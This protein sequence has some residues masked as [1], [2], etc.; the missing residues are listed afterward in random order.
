[1]RSVL[2]AKFYNQLWLKSSD[3]V[4]G[5]LNDDGINVL[6]WVEHEREIMLETVLTDRAKRKRASVIPSPRYSTI[7][8]SRASSRG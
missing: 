6:A 8:P 1:M 3:R 5:K 2:S 7:P 4:D